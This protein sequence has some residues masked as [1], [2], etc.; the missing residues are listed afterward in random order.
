M[1]THPVRH[2]NWC[3]VFVFNCLISD[4]MPPPFA[5]LQTNNFLPLTPHHAHHIDS[6]SH[7]SRWEGPMPLPFLLC[8]HRWLHLPPP[9]MHFRKSRRLT[10]PNQE[11]KY[12]PN[13]SD[14]DRILIQLLMS[15]RHLTLGGCLI[16]LG[17]RSDRFYDIKE[18]MW[19]WSPG[20]H[21]RDLK[22]FFRGLSNYNALW[23]LLK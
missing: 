11:V 15:D 12:N 20:I 7:I 17:N 10:K 14:P 8:Q 13:Q 2:V 22:S 18:K 6:S 16:F 5:E 9:Q 1:T 3:N 19:I 21:F 23:N 4:R